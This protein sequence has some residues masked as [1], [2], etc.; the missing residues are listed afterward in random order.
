MANRMANNRDPGTVDDYV[1][2]TP[3][4]T[5]HTCSITSTSSRQARDAC[6]WSN[7]L[8]GVAE[9]SGSSRIGAMIGARGCIE[10]V[11]GSGNQYMIT[12]AWQGMGPVAAPTNNACGQNLYD[13][14]TNC[15]SDRCRRVVTTLVRFGTLTGP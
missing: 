7:A 5:G 10:L 12:V 6:E 4:G 3:L 2:N 13:N 9:T 1:T 15:T 14:G 8:Q 11:P